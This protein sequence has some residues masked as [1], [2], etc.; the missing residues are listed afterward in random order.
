M[1]E[2]KATEEAA[3]LATANTKAFDELLKR[4]NLLTT[5]HDEMAKKLIAAEKLAS[6]YQAESETKDYMSSECSR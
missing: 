2:R 4:H 1:A 5:A 3:A 6:K